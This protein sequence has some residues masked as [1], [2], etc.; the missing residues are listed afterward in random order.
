MAGRISSGWALT[1]QSWK[2]LRS[3]PSLMVFPM[4]SGI[5]V[6]IVI[7]AIA[8]PTILLDP[9]LLSDASDNPHFNDPIFY[10]ASIAGIYICTFIFA[11]FNVALAAC[12]IRSLRGENTGVR[13]G[14]RAAAHRLGPI[15]GWTLVAGTI[16][17]VLDAL[18][19]RGWAGRIATSLA[20]AAWSVA[21][22]F[23]I[24]VIAAEGDGPWRA[25]KRSSAVV[26]HRWGEGATGTVTVGVIAGFLF[27]PPLLVGIMALPVFLAT[28]GEA[29]GIAVFAL[30]VV[31]ACVVACAFILIASSALTG[32][33]RVAVYQYAVT[34]EIARGFDGESLRG[35]VLSGRS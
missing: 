16:G 7:A 32:V 1:K 24:P 34:G 12:A 23:V 35:A 21:T 4:L 11:F 19:D 30:L 8:T 10:V 33:F 20:G 18:K 15:L 5:C 2:A 13:E 27:L 25:L 22:F 14:L 17:V 28:A 3:D 6:L 29:N 26:K 31:I 9:E